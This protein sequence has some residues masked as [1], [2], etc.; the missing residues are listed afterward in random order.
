VNV[1]RRRW[2]VVALVTVV[3]LAGTLGGLVVGGRS[4][5]A[6]ATVRIPAARDDLQ[7]TD[8]L[9]NTY[10]RIA[11]SAP[12][13]D[14]VQRRVGGAGGLGL[15]ATPVPNTELMELTAR[16][17]SLD[18]A[19][20]AADIWATVLVSRVRRDARE[21]QS[22]ARARLTSELANSEQRLLRLRRQLAT[23]TDRVRRLELGERLRVGQLA[24]EALAAQA[25]TGLDGRDLRNVMS[26]SQRA[27]PNSGQW[28][29]AA[30]E[31]ALGLVLG[32]VAGV[33]LA[34]V[35]ERRKPQ[36]DTLEE[37]ERAAG[38]SVLATIP[39]FRADTPTSPKARAVDF[40]QV[41][42]HALRPALNGA[43]VPH[44]A[45]GNLRAWLL[46]DETVSQELP[47]DLLAKGVAAGRPSRTLL[48]TSAKQGDGKST[49]AGNLAV[50]L[51]RARHRVLL[52]DGDL[53]HPTL[54]RYFAL[55]NEHGLSELLLAPREPSLSRC[56]AETAKTPLPKLSVLPGG[57]RA[58]EAAE[59]LA[60][61]RMADV[62]ARLKPDYDFIV[63]DSPGLAT[64]SDAAAVVPSVDA[65]I[66][67]VGGTP[68][69]DDTIHG[70]RRQ[71]DGWGARTVGIVVNRCGPQT[72][73]RGVAP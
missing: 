62:I 34:F 22:A 64:T 55:P 26:I 48:V 18:L 1:L 23:T 32:L 12:V 41:L 52:V 60:S 47:P 31:L 16:A 58:A 20:R 21:D 8:R 39:T 42:P 54:H 29:R 25:A 2:R 14:D 71:L 28:R 59:L 11:E 61:T 40:V 67:V 49:V 35:L 3:A 66:F 56:Q 46:S 13:R 5:A 9:T 19:R 63:I 15:S 73:A 72:G 17:P 70:A 45:F 27:T 38:A 50:A 37:I 68:V 30:G 33:G 6:T 10:K 53:R 65:V 43:S 57:P 4:R 7:Y 44:A 24:H 69:S 51:S 36:L